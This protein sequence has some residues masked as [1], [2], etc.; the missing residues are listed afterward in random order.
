MARPSGSVILCMFVWALLASDVFAQ[1]ITLR[2]VGAVNDGMAGAG[3]AAPLDAAGAIHWNPASIA[4]FDNNQASF[5]MMMVL[6]ELEVASSIGPFSG[7]S[8]SESGIAPIPVMALVHKTCNPRVNLGIGIYGIAGFKVN[9]D[10]SLSN[11]IL[12][13]QG[14]LGAIPTFGRVNTEAEFFQIAPTVS[15][16]LTER[17]SI[18]MAPTMTVGQLSISPFFGSPPV[19]GAYPDSAGSRYHFGGGAQFGLY[20]L[21]NPNWTFGASLKTPQWFE[22]FRFKAQDSNGLPVNA[23]LKFDYPLIASF[24]TAYYGIPGVVWATDFRYLDYANTDGFGDSGVNP[25][26]TIAGTGWSSLFSVATGIQK[27]MSQRLTLR[28]GYVFNTNPI[29]ENNV[30]INVAA[31]VITQHI[32]TVGMSYRLT[33][34]LAASLAYLHAFENS[35]SGPYLDV[36]PGSSIELTTAAYAIS[37]GLSVSW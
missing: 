30:L 4:A 32:A 18:G 1:G 24:G 36:V 15:F 2:G 11:P 13:P 6:P 33:E 31:P 19:N 20:Y 10:A 27:Q 22:E 7:S 29:N 12:F 5:G 37:S 8:S 34:N 35:Q 17:L 14:S 9:Y 23:R 28:C 16:A 3:V 21:V 25:D 26:G